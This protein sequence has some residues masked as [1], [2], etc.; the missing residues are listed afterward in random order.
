MVDAGINKP[1]AKRRLTSFSESHPLHLP[2]CNVLIPRLDHSI[3]KTDYT[4]MTALANHLPL[5]ASRPRGQHSAMRSEGPRDSQPDKRAPRKVAR[6]IA[7]A[8]QPTGRFSPNSCY[9]GSKYP[10][11]QTNAC[12]DVI[13]L[14]RLTLN[15]TSLPAYSRAQLVPPIFSWPP[16]IP[17][18]FDF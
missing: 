18:V 12:P 2:S 10:E 8:L 15:A 9:S 3:K 7:T 17:S 16:P 14:S 6:S 1:A 5:A 13:A 4:S 11:T